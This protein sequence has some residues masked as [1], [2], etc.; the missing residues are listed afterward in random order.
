MFPSYFLISFIFSFLPLIFSFSLDSEDAPIGRQILTEAPTDSP[1]SFPLGP[2][3]NQTAE[4]PQR[5]R[6]SRPTCSTPDSMPNSNYTTDDAA[7]TEILSSPQSAADEDEDQPNTFVFPSK[8]LVS[9]LGSIYSNLGFIQSGGDSSSSD[10]GSDTCETLPKEVSL[11]TES[12]KKREKGYVLDQKHA[13][14]RESDWIDEGTTE[15]A[16][17]EPQNSHSSSRSSL[18][19]LRASGSECMS[20]L[21]EAPESH[22]GRRL[23]D[24]S[25][26]AEDEAENEVSVILRRKT[27]QKGGETNAERDGNRT[28]GSSSFKPEANEH[29]G[30]AK[31]VPPAKPP[32]HRSSVRTKNIDEKRRSK[33]DPVRYKKVSSQGELSSQRS[34][35]M[36]NILEATDERCSQPSRNSAREMTGLLQ[37]PTEAHGYK[38][39]RRPRSS[40]K[41]KEA[42]KIVSSI[43]SKKPPFAPLLHRKEREYSSKHCK[44]FPFFSFF[45]L[46]LRKRLTRVEH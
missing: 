28:T 33:E 5:R 13:W 29:S 38:R 20:W 2:Y 31:K 7:P 25:N 12:Q 42:A 30:Q 46:T 27:A 3:P 36:D 15:S 23:H 26:A 10:S 45:S 16:L 21:K 41:Y 14:S 19:S 35:S 11:D 24:S 18:G 39:E 40:F 1:L 4:T 9:R 6:W 22:D 43:I 34:S 37:T 44:V 17:T 32:R 8:I